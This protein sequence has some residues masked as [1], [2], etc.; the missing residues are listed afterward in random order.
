MAPEPATQ[1]ELFFKTYN[2]N[3]QTTVVLLHGLFS[4]HLE[5]EHVIPSLA[6]YHLIVPDLP[7]HS[8]SRHIKPWSLDLAA[9][10]TA[11]LI[12]D[13][14][15]DGQA[16]L[17]GLSLGGFVAMQVLRQYPDLV[18]STFVT[19]ATPFRPWQIWLAQRSGTIHYGLKFVMGSGIYSLSAW[20]AGLKDHTQLKAEMVANNDWTLVRDAFGELAKWQWDDV[21]DVATKGKRVL[22]AAGDQGDDVEA[23]RNMARCFREKGSGE[24]LKSKAYVVEGAVHAWDLQFPS[25]FAWGITAWIK[26]QILPQGFE[27]LEDL[28]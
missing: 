2:E 23:A 8:G 24:G 17:V 19:G 11:Q 6:D 18:K 13:H 5:W 16:H 1:E 15:H 20:K 9:S 22:V 12:R 7:Q 14:A 21:Q 10:S 3:C 28:K 27:E 25:L 4:C 26:G